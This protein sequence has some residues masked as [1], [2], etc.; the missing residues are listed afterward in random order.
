MSSSIRRPR[1][2]GSSPRSS[3]TWRTTASSRRANSRRESGGCS[4]FAPVLARKM[5]QVLRHRHYLP[6]RPEVGQPPGEPPVPVVLTDGPRRVQ[7]LAPAERVVDGGLDGVGARRVEELEQ[8]RVRLMGE[9]VAVSPQAIEEWLLELLAALVIGKPLPPGDER[10]G[11]V[12]PGDRERCV[13]KAAHVPG[14]A[15]IVLPA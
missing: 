15:L 4:A 11:V 3:R 10:L 2:W 7:P 12:G 5:C 8:R 13:G 1:A 9:A 6:F 14:N